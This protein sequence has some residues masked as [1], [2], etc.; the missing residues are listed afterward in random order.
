MV[1][2]RITD[3]DVTR[4]MLKEA[5]NIESQ[6]EE[7]EKSR[8]VRLAMRYNEARGKR[9]QYLQDLKQLERLGRRLR[10]IGWEDEDE[11]T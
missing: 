9:L 10:D 5:V 4:S 2:K 7:L 8:D 3:E 11:G 1:K 6:I